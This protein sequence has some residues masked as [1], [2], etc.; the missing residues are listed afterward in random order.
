MLGRVPV[1]DR[2]TICGL[3]LALSVTEMLAVR[4]PVAVGLNVTL[5]VQFAPAARVAGETGQL[6][7][8]VKSPG[9]APVIPK[10]LIVMGALPVLLSVALWAV[11]LVPTF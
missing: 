11:L 5:I 4:E 1:P 3:P 9:F 10:A 6:F 8:R 2:A 7:A